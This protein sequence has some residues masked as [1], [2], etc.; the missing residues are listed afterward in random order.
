MLFN[1]VVGQREIKKKLRSTVSQNRISHA[2]LFTGKDGFGSLALALAYCQYISCKNRGEVDSCGTCPSCIKFNNFSHPDLHFSFP[3]NSPKGGRKVET[4]EDLMADWRSLLE[5]DT[6]FDLSDWNRHISVD[7]K[8]VLINVKE[9]QRIIKALAYKPFEAE[10]RFLIIWKADKLNV[11]AANKLLKQIEEPNAKT[12]IILV[13][14]SKESL[15]STIISRTQEVR[16]APID[17]ESILDSLSKSFPNNEDLIRAAKSGNGDLIAS[18][19]LL[20]SNEDLEQQFNWFKGWMRA[21]YKADIQAMHKWVDEIS[22][23]KVGRENRMQFLV[24]AGKIMRAGILKNYKG[25]Y[26][27]NLQAAEIDFVHRFAPFVHASN[28]ME[29]RIIV[30]EAHYHISRN[31]Y[32]KIVFMDLSMQFANLLHVKNVHL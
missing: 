11:D 20:E 14:E 6:Y 30:D 25:P 7:N 21:C 27:D 23:S 17:E 1:E 22:S 16:L 8:Q 10:Y 12:L 26:Q 28:I 18:R 32:S 5:K 19:R 15:L 9:S 31:A 4:A 3:Y 24:Y 13:T 29:M 2:Q